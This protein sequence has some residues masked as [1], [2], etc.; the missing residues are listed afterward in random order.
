MTDENLVQLP[1]M[2]TVVDALTKHN[3]SFDVFSSVR[4]EPTDVR[5]KHKVA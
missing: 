4:V 2:T 3:V 1:V 5:Y